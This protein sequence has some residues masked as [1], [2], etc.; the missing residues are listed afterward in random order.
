MSTT[1]KPASREET[2]RA[3][4]RQQAEPKKVARAKLMATQPVDNLAW[5]RELERRAIIEETA[6]EPFLGLI[7]EGKVTPSPELP[8][9]NMITAL[10][11]YLE[12]DPSQRPTA[13]EMDDDPKPR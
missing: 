1:T 10:F 2:R 11:N 4:Q 8:L 9:S 12:I 3:K 6:V 7:R 5:H 13:V